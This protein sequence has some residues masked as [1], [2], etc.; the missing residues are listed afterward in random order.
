VPALTIRDVTERPETIES[1]SNML[2]SVLPD[3]IL[4]AMK[5]VLED[6]RAWKPPVEYLD[7]GVSSKVVRI[8]LGYR[9]KAF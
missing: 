4:D 9:H 3:L 7:T 1:G 5:V 6:K 8:V 2:T